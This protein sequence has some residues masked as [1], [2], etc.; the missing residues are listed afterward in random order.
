MNVAR[1][2]ERAPKHYTSK[3]LCI[4]EDTDLPLSDFSR[5]VAVLSR[6]M[7]DAGAEKGCRIAV[8]VS[9]RPELLVGLFAIWTIGA[10]AV[11][12][13]P[14]LAGPEVRAIVE[15]CEPT[16]VLAEASLLNLLTGCGSRFELFVID[17]DLGSDRA[18]RHEKLA[19]GPAICAT[20]PTDPALIY[21]TS[22]TTG[23]PKGA[24]ISHE[25]VA[26]TA[27]MF[28]D[29]LMIGPVDRLLITGPMA[30]ILHL[31]MNALTA[32]SNGASIVILEKFR[33]D[34]AIEAINRHQITVLIAVPTAY[35]M[36]LNFL[37][38]RCI[39][40][41]SVRLGIS[42][43][44]AFPE[45][46]SKRIQDGLGLCV[47]DL[48]GM[49]ECGPITTYDPRRDRTGRP[50]SCGRTL[51]SCHIRIV[52]DG[53]QDLAVGEVGEV[54][55]RS[56]GLMT[57]YYRNPRATDEAISDGWMRS[58]DLGRVDADGLLYIVGRK[59]D[60]IVRGGANIYPVDIEEVLYSHDAVGECA[61]VGVPDPLFGEIV[62][63]FVVLRD[64]RTL[65]ASDLVEYC[66]A[67]IAEYK[68]PS[69]IEIAKSLP[70]GATGKILRRQ[71]RHMAAANTL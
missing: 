35:T 27:E 47:F 44:A 1:L 54:I 56:P 3:P 46:L 16:I 12:I 9:N 63:A 30:F 61:V 24:V 41:P 42:A 68:V 55:L 38:G 37:G 29:H 62:K 26:A 2:L 14:A 18:S 28:A 6:R 31:T 40:L 39:T 64:G 59:K 15:H 65:H 57:G 49:T 32:I 69:Q 22:G 50:D 17:R 20:E 70:K 4:F 58:G 11:P 8:L 66:R 21:Y 23:T 45:A 43:G 36:M 33:P 67:R 53:F 13:N 51:P 25:A 71:L 60:M 19:F 10:V 52:D 48:W 34:V 5:Q 7:M